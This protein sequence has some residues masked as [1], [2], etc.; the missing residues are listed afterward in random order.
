MAETVAIIVDIVGS[1]RAGRG[2]S[3]VSWNRM[4]RCLSLQ[5]ARRSSVSF[6]AN[7][8]PS[9]RLSYSPFLT[10]SRMAA[11]IFFATSGKT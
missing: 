10:R 1:R 2:G 4:R 5:M 8:L 7:A 6:S 9:V 11:S 3:G